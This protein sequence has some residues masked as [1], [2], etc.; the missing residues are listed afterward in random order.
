MTLATFGSFPN[1]FR[2]RT[3]ITFG[4]AR[5]E[6]VHLDLF[7]VGGRRIATLLRG[8]TYPAG[9]HSITWEP[10]ARLPRG[11]YLYEVRAGA[12]IR[13]GRVVLK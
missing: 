6:A 2:G 10:E 4:L 8:A 7:D 12:V 13:T 11:I 5:E 9:R 1:P 3:H